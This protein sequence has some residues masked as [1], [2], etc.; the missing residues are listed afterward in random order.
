M[1]LKWD[2]STPRAGYPVQGYQVSAARVDG[3]ADP[4]VYDVGDGKTGA[5]VTGLISGTRYSITVRLYMSVYL[6]IYLYMER[7]RE[8]GGICVSVC[9][10]V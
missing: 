6:S 7:G 9:V 8:G 3:A 1:A 4:V 2:P 10:C 5:E